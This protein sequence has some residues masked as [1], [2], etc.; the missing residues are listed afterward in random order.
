MI[1]IFRTGILILSLIWLSNCGYTPLLSSVKKNFYIESL[2][3]DGN[4][5]VNNSIG[6]MLKK[7]KGYKE[8]LIK[9]DLDI[10]SKY[11]KNIVN[12][13]SSGNPKNYEIIVTVNMN[14]QKND[15]SEINKTFQRNVSLASQSKKSK[16]RD[17]EKKLRKDLSK[18]IT[19]DII[20]FLTN[21]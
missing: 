17:L 8:N 5:Q 20:F 16:E 12:K 13:D 10:L 2:D 3:F 11:E 21:P 4:R 18:L 19:E 7:Y 14:Y 9:Y 1:K 15:G 6:S